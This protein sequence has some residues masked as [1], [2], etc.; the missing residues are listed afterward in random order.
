MTDFQ[1]RE[2]VM[3]DQNPEKII[4]QIRDLE[5]R[6]AA[7]EVSRRLAEEANGGVRAALRT[8][9]ARID[10]LGFG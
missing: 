6:L 8:F 2:I 9:V 3:I 5:R 1:I 4:H 7:S 10:R